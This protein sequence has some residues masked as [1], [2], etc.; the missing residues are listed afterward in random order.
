MRES[1]CI[2]IIDIILIINIVLIPRVILPGYEGLAW[3]TD[4]N[5]SKNNNMLRYPIPSGIKKR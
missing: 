2:R 4:L 1:L 5:Y 3:Y